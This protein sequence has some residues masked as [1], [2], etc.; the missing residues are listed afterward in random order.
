MGFLEIFGAFVLLYNLFYLLIPLFLDCDMLLA[1]KEKF[2]KPADSLAGKVIWIIGASSGIGEHTAYELANAGCKLV[3]SARRDDLLQKVKENCLAD[4]KKNV[5][6]KDILVLSFNIRDSDLH[7]KMFDKVLS[8]FGK[9]DILVHN[10]GRSQRAIWE[11][12]DLK[13]DRDAFDLNVFSLINLSRVVLKYFL[14]QGGGHFAINSS[15]AGILGAPFSG[16]YTGSKHALHGYFESLRT[17]KFGKNIAITMI[18][19]G[20]IQ[21]DFLRES[22]TEKA[23]EKFGEETQVSAKKMSSKRCAELISIALA[24]QLNEVWI[25]FY[26]ALLFAYLKFYPN[27][28]MI[29]LHL[30]GPRF[31]QK[32]RDSKVTVKE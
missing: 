6:E 27:L 20:P 32:I 7:Q 12:I 18:C 4:N 14:A 23:G 8:E 11:N 2:G 5:T 16:S 21:T 24:N 17:E 9:L 13:V 29:I 25:S 30:L 3:L 31:I 26:P 15:L 19:P 10:A 1:L 22:F 28:N